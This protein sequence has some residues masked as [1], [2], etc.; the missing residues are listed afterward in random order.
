MLKK[1]AAPSQ[2]SRPAAIHVHRREPLGVATGGGDALPDF[3]LAEVLVR[4]RGLEPPARGAMAVDGL[5]GR[6][7]ACHANGRHRAAGDGG[8]VGTDRGG[9]AL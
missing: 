6:C 5:Q 2:P 4:Q 7:L 8:D 9:Q 1:R 3:A